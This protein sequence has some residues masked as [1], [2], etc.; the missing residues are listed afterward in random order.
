MSAA[1]ILGL[2][3]GPGR[4]LSAEERGHVRDAL[5]A[6]MHD[7]TKARR[8]WSQLERLL[9]KRLAHRPPRDGG[10]TDQQDMLLLTAYETHNMLAPNTSVRAYAQY[11]LKYDIFKLKSTDFCS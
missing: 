11:I 3:E 4:P 1:E 6:V 8:I 5:F 9:P 10:R 7:K 2:K